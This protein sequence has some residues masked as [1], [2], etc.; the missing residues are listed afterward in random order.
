MSVIDGRCLPKPFQPIIPHPRVKILGID[1]A[2]F[3]LF[4]AWLIGK[5]AVCWRCGAI[6]I[7][8]PLG[9]L[10]ICPTCGLDFND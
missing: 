10:E 2:G 5:E 4:R 9:T 7:D 8:D 3:T 6:H 1:T